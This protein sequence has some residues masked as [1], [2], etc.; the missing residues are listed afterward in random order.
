[1]LTLTSLKRRF[2]SLI[3]DNQLFTT[4]P[5]KFAPTSQNVRFNLHKFVLLKVNLLTISLCLLSF[6]FAYS[7]CSIDCGS[8][9]GGQSNLSSWNKVKFYTKTVNATNYDADVLSSYNLGGIAN[10]TGAQSFGVG[11]AGPSNINDRFKEINYIVEKNRSEKLLVDFGACQSFTGA[12]ITLAKFYGRE[13]Q[14]KGE[15]GCWRAFD[16]NFKQVGGGTFFANQPMGEGNPGLFTFDLRSGAPFRYL[17]FTA[18]PYINSLLKTNFEESSDYLLQKIVP[19]CNA[20]PKSDD[21][22]GGTNEYGTWNQVAV[23]TRS[24]NSEIFKFTNSS[25]FVPE[26]GGISGSSGLGVPDDEEEEINYNPI[27]GKSEALRIDLGKKNKSALFTVARLF[28]GEQGFWVAYNLSGCEYV[29]V[30]RGSFKGEEESGGIL[31]SGGTSGQRTVTVSTTSDFQVI[32]FTSGPTQSTKSQKDGEEGSG[33]I[34]HQFIPSPICSGAIEV[35]SYDPANNRDGSYINEAFSNPNNAIGPAQNNDSFE[36]V[37]FVSLGFGGSIVLKF[38]QPILNGPGDDVSIF[39]TSESFYEESAKKGTGNQKTDSEEEE[40]DGFQEKA[41][42][43]ASQNGVDYIYLGTVTEDGTVDLGNLN[44]ALYIKILDATCKNNSENPKDNGY[45]L[46]GINCLNGRATNPVPQNIIACSAQSVKAYSPGTK[47]NGTPLL[48]SRDNPNEALGEPNAE[49]KFNF[50]VALGFGDGRQKGINATT[51]FIELGFD[52]VIFDK[53]NAKD[54]L[55][56]ETSTNSNAGGPPFRNYPEQAKVYASKDGIKWVYLGKTNVINPNQDCNLLLDTEFDFAG[57]IAWARFIKI[58]D[59]T[60]PNARRRRSD[61]CA[62]ISNQF[63]F[64]NGADAFDVDAV[65]CAYSEEGESARQKS[66]NAEKVKNQL[67]NYEMEA[68]KLYP[69]PAQ[70]YI[71]LDLSEAAE[72]VTPDDGKLSVKIF[73]SYGKLMQQNTVEIN[74]DFGTELNISSLPKGV[75]ILKFESGSSQRTLRF[76]K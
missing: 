5:S 48:D 12:I 17:E 72:F 50:S 70:E 34:L 2:K 43:F 29:E 32:E 28:E 27:L 18:L 10:I 38:A 53:P 19:T 46:D 7:Q 62:I 30:G 36:P 16:K 40:C 66:K 37:N 24:V 14:M 11:V 65:V 75:Y 33:Y 44:W 25:I 26:G 20:I 73:T 61:N 31:K 59:I 67:T 1:M 63:A 8:T 3:F 35:V 39:E 64:N 74:G 21:I 13:N 6:S 45:D 58:I 42:V 51:G 49:D 47:K 55:V 23:T 22:L 60:D 68:L 52:A 9:V 15:A 57:K 76:I 69:N 71:N 56:V 54:I 4:T 41:D